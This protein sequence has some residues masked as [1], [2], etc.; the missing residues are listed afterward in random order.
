MA[1]ISWLDKIDGGDLGN[2]RMNVNASDMNAIKN[3]VNENAALMALLS[4]FVENEVP[5]GSGTDF[6]IANT[7][8]A[9]SV[10]LYRN[11]IRQTITTDYTISGAN[12]TLTSTIG[13]DTLLADYRK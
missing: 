13:S 3:T 12:I 10:K 7:P 11:G 4:S 6:T 5:S 2:P 8:V 1:T 9:G